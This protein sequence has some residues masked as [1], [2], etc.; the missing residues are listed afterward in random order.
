VSDDSTRLNFYQFLAISKVPIKKNSLRF[1]VVFLSLII[2]LFGFCVKLVLIQIFH[3]THL[4]SL[5]EKQHNHSIEI[6]PIRGTIYDRNLRPLALNVSVYSLFANPRGM[7]PT[8]KKKALASLP[9][10]LGID[11]QELANKIEKKK[12]FV[13]LKRKLSMETVAEIKKLKI[14]GLGFIDES[15]RYYPNANLAAHVI[16]F[17]G[18]DNEGLEGIELFYDKYLRGEAGW[19]EILRD[20]RQRELMIEKQYIPP[21]D[22]M[23]L[24]LT[25]DETIQYLAEKALDEAYKKNNALSASIIVI[26]VKTGEILAL[27]N[28]PTYSLSEAAKSPI[29]NRTNRAVSF[30]YE[31]G[32]VFKIVTAAAALEE[33]AFK[34]TDKIY[35]ENGEYRVANH[36]LHDHGKHG[37]ISFKEVFEVSS[38]IGVTKIAQKLGP[39]EI[40]KYGQRFRFGRKTGVDLK[41]EIGGLFK[42]PKTWSKTSIGAVPIGH[43]VGVTPLQL[44]CAISAI[45]NHGVY[46]RPYVVKEIRDASDEVVKAFEPEMIDR[47]ISEDTAKRLNEILVGVVEEGTGTKAKIAGMRVAGKTGT[48]QKALGGIYSHSKFY[49]TFFGYA[50]A[51]DPKLAAIVVFD[52]PHP[53]YFGGTVAAPVFRQVVEDSLKYLKNS[54]SDFAYNS[55]PLPPALLKKK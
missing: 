6:E 4:A 26:D 7:S 30:M 16:G 12:Y 39:N 15:K 43:E 18:I 10:L 24:V 33:N 49:S 25:L 36:I 22:G 1:G 51:D 31:P 27:A 45:A 14:K 44:I 23:N 5:A 47:V 29:E 13:W 19:A 3:S 46:M 38:N 34:E 52:E 35:C 37:L 54:G 55:Q 8:M 32:S 20:A 40:Y 48:A 41:G 11:R 53:S 17:A 42:S 9:T 21:R 28:R 50:P 2:F